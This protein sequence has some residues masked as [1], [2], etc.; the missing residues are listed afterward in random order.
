MVADGS[1]G[2]GKTEGGPTE[3][4]SGPRSEEHTSE[5]QSQSNL[6]C[7]LPLDKKGFLVGRR[8]GTFARPFPRV[9]YWFKRYPNAVTRRLAA[10][11]RAD[12]RRRRRTRSF[13]SKL[14]HRRHS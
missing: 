5:L 10:N 6:V 7:R 9:R 4:A 3:C 1:A 14:K 8:R 12:T 13:C 11:V 2:R